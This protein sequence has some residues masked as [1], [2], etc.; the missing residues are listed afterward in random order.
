[1]KRLT[2]DEFIRKANEVHKNKYD[3]SSINYV[4]AFKEG[5]KIKCPIHGNFFKKPS[6]HIK[7]YGCPY[8]GGTA[9]LGTE[10]FVSKAR[11]KHGNKYS[12][13]KVKY[14][15]NRT[16]VIITCPIHGDFSQTP[17]SHLGGNGCS[18]CGKISSSKKLVMT[19]NEFIEKATL[20]HNR[21]YEY[22]KVVYE[23]SKLPVIITC[24]EHGDFQQSPNQHL[25]G[26]GCSECSGTK[27]L[28]TNSFIVKANIV[29]HNRYDYSKV[30]Y[31]NNSIKVKIICKEHGD[32]SQSPMKHLQGQGCRACA[33]NRNHS[34]E[35]F[36]AK[37]NK[38]HDNKF[39]YERSNFINVKTKITITC[40]VHGEFE[41]IPSEHLS[42]YGCK[43]CGNNTKYSTEEFVSK[44]REIHG[45]KY[46][47]QYVV[48]E[49]STR[50]I[51][52]ECPFHGF[53]EQRPT[54]H[55]NGQGCPKCNLPKGEQRIIK[56]LENLKMSFITQFTF[57]DCFHIKP[58]PFDFMVIKDSVKYLIEFH[59][60]QHYKS[61]NYGRNKTNFDYRKQLD[62]IKM[63]YATKNN[64]P[65]LEI[66][67]T[68][69]DRVEELV[70]NF[71][72]IT[73]KNN[74]PPKP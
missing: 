64:I 25:Q 3:Y 38:I 63:D 31:I 6:A 17:S 58:L 47:Y 59:G 42:G 10:S 43:K 9:K 24:K 44:A 70:N 4:Y 49:S 13:E 5:V 66:P 34:F 57:K 37:A 16:K 26:Y 52:I 11:L 62:K 2:V 32:F 55:L 36:K 15:N 21:R 20:K 30:C 54:N 48:Y 72:G 14:I 65:F 51:K 45:D 53:F 40:P 60:E 50:K 29:H 33:G 18:K 41:Q 1:M 69:M 12:Y 39:T 73:V 22:D 7:G 23:N 27:K 71:L 67:Y 68:E 61:I 35:S 46:G 28:N 74:P 8:C 56:H 19:Q